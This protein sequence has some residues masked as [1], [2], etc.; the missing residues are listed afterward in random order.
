MQC[1]RALVLRNGLKA[2]RSIQRESAFRRVA[3]HRTGPIESDIDVDH[4]P[5]SVKMRR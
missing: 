5:R 3:L 4:S 2:M 1:A